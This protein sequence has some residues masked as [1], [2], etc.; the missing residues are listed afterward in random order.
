[1]ST[2]LP[3]C[4]IGGAAAVWVEA[5]VATASTTAAAARHSDVFEWVIEES[6]LAR[7]V[8]PSAAVGG[9]ECRESTLG[10]EAETA[11]VLLGPEGQLHGPE[12]VRLGH[13]GLGALQH[14]VHELPAV[15]QLHVLRVDVARLLLVHHEEVTAPGPAR[16]V[17]V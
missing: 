4:S 10:V 5:G 17:D 6:P 13:G 12:A 2:V 14:V 9:Q 7:P 8:G 16:D 1:M 11:R 3:G 15:G